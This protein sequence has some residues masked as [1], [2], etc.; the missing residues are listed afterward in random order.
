MKLTVILFH[1]SQGLRKY[2]Q[3]IVAIAL[4][5]LN[6][7]NSLNNLGNLLFQIKVFKSLKLLKFRKLSFRTKKTVYT[8]TC[9]TGLKKLLNPFLSSMI[10][11]TILLLRINYCLYILLCWID[12]RDFLPNAIII[13]LKIRKAL[14][15]QLKLNRQQTGQIHYLIQLTPISFFLK[16][17]QNPS[18]PLFHHFYQLLLFKLGLLSVLLNQFLHL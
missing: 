16:N 14:F 13:F 4:I 3:W 10:Q 12:V 6:L 8:L 15:N 17:L 7:L 2:F 1:F 9:F 5:Y 18:V 11:T